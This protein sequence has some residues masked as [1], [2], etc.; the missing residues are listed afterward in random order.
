[1][2]CLLQDI[3]KMVPER[4]KEREKGT[5]TSISCTDLAGL[6]H[7]CKKW[8]DCTGSE[9]P[10]PI[11]K[12]SGEELAGN[13]CH[14]DLP[15]WAGRGAWPALP[16]MTR[17]PSF[18]RAASSQAWPDGCNAPVSICTCPHHPC[19]QAELRLKSDPPRITRFLKADHSRALQKPPGPCRSL[20]QEE[21]GCKEAAELGR[22]Q[23][24]ST[25]PA[26]VQ[27]SGPLGCYNPAPRLQQSRWEPAWGWTPHLGH[28]C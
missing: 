15:H 14:L 7:G 25:A 2:K 22:A 9:T 18:T 11:G 26:R 28:I 21:A 6:S 12:Y 13:L 5:P 8:C 17:R 19:R 23:E 4:E 16:T 1:M 24:L 10:W 27:I 20:Q 3:F